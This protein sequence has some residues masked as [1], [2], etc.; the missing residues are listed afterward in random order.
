MAEREQRRR[1]IRQHHLFDQRLKIDVV[2]GE[3][4]HVALVAIAERALRKTLA[5][6]IDHGD[7]EAALARV[8]DHLEIFL[9]EFGPP[10][11]YA[12]RSLASRWRVPAGEPQT[13]AVLG[14][15]HPDHRAL[16]SRVGGDRD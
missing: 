11:E 14:P 3:A 12:Q 15:E 2:I 7:R 8:V 4:A 13:D 9:D 16:G 1:A 5:A 6:Q 10:R